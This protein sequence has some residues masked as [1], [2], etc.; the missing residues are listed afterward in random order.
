MET[1]IN[2]VD[3]LQG[4][5]GGSSFHCCVPQC[6]GDARYDTSLSFHRLPSMSK[7]KHL[8]AIWLSKIQR[9]VGKY[10]QITCSTRV[11]SRHFLPDDFVRSVNGR[12]LLKENAVPTIFQWSVQSQ[13]TRREIRRHVER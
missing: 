3:P 11:C 1:P 2:S 10:F 6:G 9:K 13:K 4:R 5:R 12:L 8:R 7:R